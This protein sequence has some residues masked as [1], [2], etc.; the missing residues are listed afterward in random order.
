GLVALQTAVIT[1]A[2]PFCVI[3]CFI[4]YSLL[5][6]LKTETELKKAGYNTERNDVLLS[7][8]AIAVPGTAPV[9]TPISETF[10]IEGNNTLANINMKDEIS[11]AMGKEE[12]AKDWRSRLKRLEKKHDREYLR[13]VMEQS[14]AENAGRVDKELQEFISKVV[15]PAFSEIEQELVKYD[16]K[17]KISISHHQASIIVMKNNIEELYYGIR[18][19]AYHKFSYSFPSFKATDVEVAAYAQVVLRGGSRKL[20]ELKKFTKKGIIHDFLNEYEKWAILS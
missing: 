10:D 19:R 6:A 9:D 17:V 4:C 1:S 12:H 20:H 5:K 8:N 7:K 3:I 14:S 13:D 16:R 15:K 2:L 11:E 18:G